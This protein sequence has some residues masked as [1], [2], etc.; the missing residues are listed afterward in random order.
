MKQTK[1]ASTQNTMISG[2]NIYQDK[3]GNTIYFDKRNKM[4]YKISKEKSKTFQ[5]L[6]MRFILTLVAFILFYILF[7]IHILIS[8]AISAV[9]FIF[10][11]YRFKKFLNTCPKS[12]NFDK[13]DK[14]KPID[15][16]IESSI[17]DLALRFGLYGILGILLIVNTFI[18]NNVK[19]QNG[20]IVASYIV[21]IFALYMAFKYLS[22]IVRK[23]KK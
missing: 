8:L 15:Q 3:V 16:M 23:T 21:A 11:E 17:Q 10:M 9:I 13:K 2:P 14:V 5:T 12:T 7:E 1:K 18:S 4:A 19:N 6:Q 20:L 22:L